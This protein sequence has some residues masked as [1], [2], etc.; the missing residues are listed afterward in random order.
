MKLYAQISN[1][2]ILPE[3]NND[4][5]KLKKLR[6]GET[7]LVE[8]KQPRNIGFHRKYMALINLVFENQEHFDNIDS[9]RHWL[10]MRAGYYV[11][12]VT[13]TGVMFEP[14]SISFAN[15]DEIE[16][17]E[18]YGRVLDEVCKF[19]DISEEEVIENIV[20]FM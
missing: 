14:K 8:I 19:L 7:Y 3:Y 5:D 6:S 12:T 13:P 20:N 10:Q 4:F 9:M 16:F 18:L 15:M 17:N 2:R 1:G 11:E